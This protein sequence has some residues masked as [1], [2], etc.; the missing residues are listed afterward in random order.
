MIY[1]DVDS[2]INLV[3]QFPNLTFMYTKVNV[4]SGGYKPANHDSR[5]HT[6][7]I[8]DSVYR[9]K[10]STCT[11]RTCVVVYQS[12]TDSKL[13][14]THLQKI[15]NA[16]AATPTFKF[17]D[18]RQVPIVNSE[19]EVYK[20]LLATS[21]LGPQLW[22]T[23]KYKDD[24]PDGTATV[25]YQTTCGKIV[26]SVFDPNAPLDI[27]G[28]GPALIRGKIS[29]RCNGRYSLLTHGPF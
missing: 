21:I 5:L 11:S 1:V 17:S 10:N 23:R 18:P 22:R 7:M 3:W 28:P 14:F 16:S 27:P 26:G 15:S 24:D 12:L 29:F 2:E 8:N 20:P 6:F 4:E 13:F 9:P 25:F 19:D